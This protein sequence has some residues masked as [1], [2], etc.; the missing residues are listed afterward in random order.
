MSLL[1][2]SSPGALRFTWEP[3]WSSP[4]LVSLSLAGPW[5]SIHP[6]SPGRHGA[7]STALLPLGRLWPATGRQAPQG[8]RCP[9]HQAT[10]GSARAQPRGTWGQLSGSNAP[11]VHGGSRGKDSQLLPAIHAQTYKNKRRVSHPPVPSPAPN[12]DALLLS[13]R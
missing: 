13:F 8:G 10:G 12:K 2:S 1:V 4:A 3:G 5:I 11:N 7:A 9:T 6:R